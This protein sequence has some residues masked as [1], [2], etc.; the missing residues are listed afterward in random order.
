MADKNM[1]ESARQEF[2]ADLHVGV[3]GVERAD[4]PPLVVPVWYSYEPGGD[5][6]VLMSSDSLK[7]RL[8][9]AAGRAALCA[10]QEALPYKYVS[11]EGPVAIAPLTTDARPEVERMAVRYLGDKMGRDYANAEIA[12]DEIK[13][14]L[15]PERWF[16]VDYG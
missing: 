14:T 8:L 4:G 13:V 11:V 15:T 9:A 3:L 5:V 6:T 10:Q 1:S 12:D 2:L 16:S 7:G